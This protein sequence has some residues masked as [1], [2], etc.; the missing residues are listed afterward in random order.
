MWSCCVAGRFRSTLSKFIL[1]PP[2]ELPEL[3]RQS[4]EAMLLQNRSNGTTLLCVEQNQGASIAVFDVTDPSHVRS[5]GAAHADAPGPF[6]FVFSFGHDGELVRFRQDQGEALLDLHR[7]SSPSLK[8]VR[9]LT[10]QGAITRLGEDGFIVANQGAVLARPTGDYQVV[11]TANLQ[12]PSSV[13]DVKQVREELTDASTGATVLLTENGLYL[14]SRPAAEMEKGIGNWR[15][16]LSH[17][18]FWR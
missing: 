8:W 9:G 13:L 18:P 2:A 11:D 10:F 6:H 14:I 7:V 15:R 5:E 16:G 17:R 12:N 1:V 4:G 3:A